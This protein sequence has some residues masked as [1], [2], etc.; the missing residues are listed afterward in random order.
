MGDE[1]KKPAKKSPTAGTRNTRGAWVTYDPSDMPVVGVYADEAGASG[2]LFEAA[3][4][5]PITDRYVF[6]PWGMTVRQAVA[7]TKTVRT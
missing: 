6:V 5:D 1:E 4:T 2:A 3:G 7:A